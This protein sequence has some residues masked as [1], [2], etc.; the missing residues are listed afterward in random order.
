MKYFGKSDILLKVTSVFL[1]IFL[2]I[3]CSKKETMFQKDADIVI[4]RHLKYYGRLI[5]EYH[6]ITGKYPLQQVMPMP[7]YVCVANDQQMEFVELQPEGPHA[8]V[9]FSVF[10]KQ[11]ESALG[12]EINEYY[13]PKDQPVYK[14]NFYVYRIHND[15]FYFTAYVHRPYSFARKVAESYYKV[16]ISNS[17]DPENKIFS[18][19]KLFNSPEFNKEINKTVSEKNFFKQRE[20]K[21]LHHTKEKKVKDVPVPEK[22]VM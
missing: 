18:P 8:E 1:V 3:G 9:P 2:L 15:T 17:P 12:R 7:F 5:D 11:I 20:G 4:L 21:F 19:E 16:V 6:E 14:P 22:D 10:V 13:D